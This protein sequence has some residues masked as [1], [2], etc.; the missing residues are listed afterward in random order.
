MAQAKQ[1]R[2]LVP[3]PAAPD[4][5]LPLVAVAA[6]ASPVL[7]EHEEHDQVDDRGGGQ[8]D[9]RPD[10]VLGTAE[11]VVGPAIFLATAESD[12]VTGSILYADGGYTSAA[13]TDDRHR[14]K[15][16]PYRGS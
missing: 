12:W 10:H 16:V 11:D 2:E 5:G 13:A 1:G 9:G 7:E 4:R 8:V 3:P 15:E 14:P 6:S